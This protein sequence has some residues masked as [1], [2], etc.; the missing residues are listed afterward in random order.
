MLKEIN[1]NSVKSKDYGQYVISLKNLKTRFLFI[2]VN[3]DFLD[4]FKKQI[5]SCNVFV[6]PDQ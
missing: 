5:A 1:D 2:S 3:N 4:F 6:L